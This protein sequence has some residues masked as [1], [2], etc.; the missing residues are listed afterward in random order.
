MSTPGQQQGIGRTLSPLVGQRVPG[1]CGRCN[2]Y[3][4][5]EPI[6]GSSGHGWTIVVH[7]DAECPFLRK[8]ER[9]AAP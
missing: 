1:G 5:A 9:K 3:Q 6:P 2:A 4:I 7:H 8:L